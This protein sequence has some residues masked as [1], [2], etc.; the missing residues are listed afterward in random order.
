MTS[1]LDTQRQR[2]SAHSDISIRNT[3]TSAIG[4]QRSRDEFIQYWRVLMAAHDEFAE[5]Q[6]ACV[7]DDNDEL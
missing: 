7:G 5:H 6:L 3:A 4:T 2:H 1:A